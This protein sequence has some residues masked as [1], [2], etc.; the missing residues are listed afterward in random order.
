MGG[1]ERDL[2]RAGIDGDGTLI[3]AEYH[4]SAT[5]PSTAVIEA[6]AAVEEVDPVALSSIEGITLHDYVDSDAL[7]RLFTDRGVDDISVTFTVDEYTVCIE[8]SEITIGHTEN[9]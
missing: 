5:A 2:E 1:T 4:R 6:I 8:R 3:E 7:D 9:R